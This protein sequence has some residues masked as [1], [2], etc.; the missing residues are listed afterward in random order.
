LTRRWA[1][2]YIDYLRTRANL[3]QDEH[4]VITVVP[5][6]SVSERADQARFERVLK[7]WRA[8]NADVEAEGSG[9]ERLARLWFSGQRAWTPAW[10]SREFEKADR[11]LRTGAAGEGRGGV[12]FCSADNPPPT[13]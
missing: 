10:L 1:R 11:V 12:V 5:I 3:A 7:A 6:N 4:G 2:T 8:E 13:G 9:R